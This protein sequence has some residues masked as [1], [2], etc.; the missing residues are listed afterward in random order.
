M[1]AQ[2]SVAFISDGKLQ[3]WLQATFGFLS[4]QQ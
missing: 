3:I 2:G 4:V 1:F